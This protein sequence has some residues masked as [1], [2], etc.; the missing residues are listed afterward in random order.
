MSLI[1]MVYSDKCESAQCDAVK[2]AI[3]QVEPELVRLFGEAMGAIT[4]GTRLP[5]LLILAVQ[6]DLGPWLSQFFSRIDFTQFTKTAQPFEIELLTPEHM[7]SL[8]TFDTGAMPDAAFAVDAALVSLE[9][10]TL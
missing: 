2:Q 4:P 10:D 9:A 1:R 7:K 6:P 5:N 8:V 3:A